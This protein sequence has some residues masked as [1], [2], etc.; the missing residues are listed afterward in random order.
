MSDKKA[1]PGCE[2]VV[3]GRSSRVYLGSNTL[4]QPYVTDILRQFVPISNDIMINERS[5]RFT[6][7]MIC[8]VLYSPGAVLVLY[9]A[10]TQ[11]PK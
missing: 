10:V 6:T 2:C 5:I 8:A 3:Q 1:V 4:S 7:Q 11:I 9:C